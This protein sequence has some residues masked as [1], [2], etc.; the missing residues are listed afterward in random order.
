[1]GNVVECSNIQPL[2]GC[3]FPMNIELS[4]IQLR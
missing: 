2:H 4:E 1:M 3:C